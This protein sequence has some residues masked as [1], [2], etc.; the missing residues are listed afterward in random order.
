MKMFSLNPTYYRL[1]I[2]DCMVIFIIAFGLSFWPKSQLSL[3]LTLLLLIW[4]IVRFIQL[5]IVVF[6]WQWGNIAVRIGS[7]LLSAV[8]M[9][10]SIGFKEQ[11]HAAILYPIYLEKIH[12]AGTSL[13]N[14]L[15]LEYSDY[16][17]GIHLYVYDISGK[18]VPGLS[19]KPGFEGMKV[20]TRHIFGPF[21]SEDAIF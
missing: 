15:V 21:F 9:L 1:L 2:L 13:D 12:A 4:F 11:I 5:L 10:A 14:P 7:F 16:G 18:E 3:L 6:R 19:F 17:P 20:Y 8:V